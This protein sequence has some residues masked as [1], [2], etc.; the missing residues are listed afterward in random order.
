[1]NR[2]IKI[3]LA[4]AILITVPK[5]IQRVMFGSPKDKAIA[6]L[7]STIQEL[8]PTLPKKIDSV[9]TLTKAEVSGDTYRIYYTM[10]PSVQV[11]ASRK[12]IVEQTAKQQICGTS[13]K[14]LT[15][16]GITVE[17][18]YTFSGQSGD[19]QMSVVVP[20]GSCS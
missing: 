17:Y 6:A 15:D 10:D 20:S 14:I 12:G 1:M 5:I 2:V 13:K 4:V 11:D 3:V 18:V 16:N 19:E 7:R 8:S 9:T